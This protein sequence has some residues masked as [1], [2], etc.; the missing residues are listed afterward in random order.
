MNT[1]VVNGKRMQVEGNSISINGNKIFVDGKELNCEELK[2]E[3]TIKWEGDLASLECHN[4]KIKG[5]IHTKET[6]HLQNT[7]QIDG[8]IV[9][10]KMI[11]DEGAKYF[12]DCKVGA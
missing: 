2:N 10:N 3:V 11:V 4:A 12:G 6:L 5:N 9:S 1:I 7:A 8:N